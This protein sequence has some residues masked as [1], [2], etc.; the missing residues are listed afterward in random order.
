M[1]GVPYNKKRDTQNFRTLS[2]VSN[3]YVKE[4]AIDLVAKR[5]P[6]SLC[7]WGFGLRAKLE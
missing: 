1:E 6:F 7:F 2:I 3:G 5:F 4:N